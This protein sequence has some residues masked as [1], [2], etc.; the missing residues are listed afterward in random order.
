M[1]MLKYNFPVF[2]CCF[3]LSLL[4]SANAF[5]HHGSITN[6]NMYFAEN[7]VEVESEITDVFWR[8]PTSP[9]QIVC[10]RQFRAVRSLGVGIVR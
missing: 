4:A 9:I 7:L 10:A 6:P 8:L 1:S 2:V 5:A 3:V